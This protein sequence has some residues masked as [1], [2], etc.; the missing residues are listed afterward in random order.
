MVVPDFIHS[1]L[2]GVLGSCA[3]V[4]VLLAACCHA[5]SMGKRRDRDGEVKGAARQEGASDH[6]PHRPAEI[7]VQERYAPQ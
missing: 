2:L 4:V 5:R 6:E 7:G 1:D 3:L